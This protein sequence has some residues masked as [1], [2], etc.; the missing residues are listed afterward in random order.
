M[1]I[2]KPRTGGQGHEQACIPGISVGTKP[3]HVCP[4]P[5][6]VG[7]YSVLPHAQVLGQV[8]IYCSI[9]TVEAC[10]PA[11]MRYQCLINGVN[12]EGLHT[13]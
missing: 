11:P 7:N 12:D 9:F 4:P 2:L 6:C 13:T 10:A 3:G 1:Q 5:L 8:K